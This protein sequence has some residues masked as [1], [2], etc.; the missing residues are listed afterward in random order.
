VY[1]PLFFLYP[2][3]R[4]LQQVIAISSEKRH[5]LKRFLCRRHYINAGG[6]QTVV[7]PFNS[8]GEI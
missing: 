8:K 3:W 6:E 2:E 1:I 5:A 7:L 4:D